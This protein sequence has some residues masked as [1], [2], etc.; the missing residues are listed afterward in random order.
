MGQVLIISSVLLLNTYWQ[1]IFIYHK[2]TANRV[3]ERIFAS[4]QK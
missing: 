2:A 3:L 4:R 1:N